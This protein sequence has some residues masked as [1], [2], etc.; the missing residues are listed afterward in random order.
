[1]ATCGSK[2]THEKD[3]CLKKDIGLR[4]AGV[5]QLLS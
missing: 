5:I 1:M 2:D 4:Y 3:T